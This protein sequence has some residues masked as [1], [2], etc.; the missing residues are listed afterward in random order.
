V[1]QYLFKP[2][3]LDSACFAIVFDSAGVVMEI[4]ML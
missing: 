2:A 4:V 1:R 3:G